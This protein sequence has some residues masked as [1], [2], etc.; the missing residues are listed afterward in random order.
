LLVSKWI[1]S[2]HEDNYEDI[3]AKLTSIDNTIF[4]NDN[5]NNTWNSFLKFTDASYDLTS[6]HRNSNV[7]SVLSSNHFFTNELMVT[8]KNNSFTINP[9][10]DPSGGCIVQIMITKLRKYR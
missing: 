3:I 6:I 8:S 9:V 2:V 7:A 1:S 4:L 5:E 10:F